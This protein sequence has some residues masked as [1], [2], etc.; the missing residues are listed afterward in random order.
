MPE[1]YQTSQRPNQD[2]PYYQ[3][4]VENLPDGVIVVDAYNDI[5]YANS[6]ALSYLQ[7]SE[8][9]VLGKNIKFGPLSGETKSII[10]PTNIDPARQRFEAHFRNV[11]WD[12]ETGFIITIK[13]QDQ[14]KHHYLSTGFAD[15][16]NKSIQLHENNELVIRFSA[17]GKL[18]EAT[19]ISPGYFTV[20][21]DN[22]KNLYIFDIL[23][24]EHGALL[25]EKIKQ[26]SLEHPTC[27]FLVHSNNNHPTIN[28][29]QFVLQALFDENGAIT[30]Y[31]LIGNVINNQFPFSTDYQLLTS[32][33]DNACLGIAIIDTNG[34]YL[35][36]NPHFYK[37]LGYSSKELLGKPINYMLSSVHTSNYYNIIHSTLNQTGTWQGECWLQHKD[38]HVF[39]ADIH[40]KSIQ[41]EGGDVCYYVLYFSDKSEL[42]LVENNLRHIALHDTLTDLPNRTLLHEKL[43]QSIRMAQKTA[44]QFAVL[45]LD[46]DGF[47]VINNTFGHT[48]GDL[49]LREVSNRLVTCVHKDDLLARMGG[50]EFAIIS[51]H[52]GNEGLVPASVTAQKIIEALTM[53]YMI[54][55]Q[56]LFMTASIGISLFPGDGE[57]AVS[58]LKNADIAMY[59]AKELGKN[60]FQF[61]SEELNRRVLK[62]RDME[63]HLR[64]ALERD[65]FKLVYQPIVEAN[66]RKIVAIEALLR[67]DHT[68]LGRIMP[69]DFIPLAEETGL[70]VEIGNWVMRTACRHQQ[71]LEQAGYPSV[72]ISINISGRQLEEEHFASTVEGIIAE[73]GINPS[74]LVL[75]ITESLL[76][77]NIEE[78]GNKLNNLR[79]IGVKISIDDFGT[80]YSSLHSLVNL[81]VDSLKID[82]SFVAAMEDNPHGLS[83]VKGVISIGHNL[84]LEIIAEGV[85]NN[86]QATV[87]E[88][89]VCDLLQGYYFGRPMSFTD[90]CKVINPSL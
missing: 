56:E 67:W 47:K 82:K 14:G 3:M 87:L 4:I 2:T 59:R 16:I 6:T 35:S 19:D 63:N 34:N 17:Q 15:K 45:H 54:D 29:L 33:I 70:I 28:R 73:S 38:Q 76:M 39:P 46:L 78:N 43:Y 49:L 5:L 24:E 40:A 81:P 83:L 30:Q 55:E 75:E 62:R 10:F 84:D 12:G 53:P 27:I 74:K 80:G 88:K 85:E 65:E 37:L 68:S 32:V 89:H 9:D 7:Q 71:T 61:Y 72:L 1:T 57:K 31:T 50:D 66:S 13:P 64:H 79:K 90:L 11:Y 77:Q 25:K 58:L 48:T 18:L 23:P 60:N 8:Q 20:D 51:Y 41:N 86:I 26:V 52:A 22:N 69:D 42:K 36:A 21:P 44:A